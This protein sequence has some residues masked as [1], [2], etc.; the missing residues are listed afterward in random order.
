MKNL[1]CNHTTIEENFKE[2][3]NELGLFRNHH[4][5]ACDFS[6][7]KFILN[8]ATNYMLK[9][10]ATVPDVYPTLWKML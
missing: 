9:V 2:V 5:T 3:A 8:G 1:F 4:L 10:W 7:V 6:D